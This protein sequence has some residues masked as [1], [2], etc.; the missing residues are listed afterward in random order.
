MGLEQEHQLPTDKSF[1]MQRDAAARGF[2]PR[3]YQKKQDGR[4]IC[5]F[6]YLEYLKAVNVQHAHDLVA[7]FSLCLQGKKNGNMVDISVGVWCS[8]C[9][10]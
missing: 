10:T 3:S 1:Q 5:R 6:S 9:L 2:C 7:G 4:L 8:A